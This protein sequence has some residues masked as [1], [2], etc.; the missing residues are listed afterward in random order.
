MLG[1]EQYAR[2]KVR[3]TLIKPKDYF[4]L[5]PLRII[6]SFRRSYSDPTTQT[7]CIKDRGMDPACRDAVADTK[8]GK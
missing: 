6:A 2:I 4:N 8:E 7:V 5:R 3:T 1:I